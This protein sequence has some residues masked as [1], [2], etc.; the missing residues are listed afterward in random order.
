MN[1]YIVEEVREAGELRV[2]IVLGDVVGQSADLLETLQQLVS[3]QFLLD[4]LFGVLL[5]EIENEIVLPVATLASGVS[6]AS[7]FALQPALLIDIQILVH[8][9]VVVIDLRAVARVVLVAV[10][11]RRIVGA[12]T[13][14]VT[15]AARRQTPGLIDRRL[16]GHIDVVRC[17]DLCMRQLAVGV[18]HPGDVVREIV[19][20]AEQFRV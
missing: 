5:L 15:V 4:G 14:L 17:F 16:I 10:I 13:A 2:R 3:D 9:L 11:H 20:L 1:L 12:E 7:P 6:V 18:V 19:Q 8:A